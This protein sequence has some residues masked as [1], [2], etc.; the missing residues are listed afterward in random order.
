[1]MATLTLQYAIEQIADW[2]SRLFLEPHIVACVA[3]MSQYSAT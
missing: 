3:V 1:M 2:H